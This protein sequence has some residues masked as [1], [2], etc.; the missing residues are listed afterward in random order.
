M[1]LELI[2]CQVETPYVIKLWTYIRISF[3]LKPLGSESKIRIAGYYSAIFNMT[4]N[5]EKDAKGC[6]ELGEELPIYEGNTAFR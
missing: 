5:D 4:K 2:A 1:L 3:E 6:Q